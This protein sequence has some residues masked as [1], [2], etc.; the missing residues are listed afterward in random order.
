[1][2]H[3][4][5]GFTY[6]LQVTH[7]KIIY[8]G[9]QSSNFKGRG[10]EVPGTFVF[11]LIVEKTVQSSVIAQGSRG[12]GHAYASVLFTLY[13]LNEKNGHPL[14]SGVGTQIHMGTISKPPG[15][16][17]NGRFAGRTRWSRQ[18]GMEPVSQASRYS[19]R[20]WS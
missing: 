7:C 10:S 8:D 12:H 4:T 11:R 19:V 20:F 3:T 14:E 1:M 13:S 18:V 15:R 17:M 5:L 9:S 2:P 6:P 16:P